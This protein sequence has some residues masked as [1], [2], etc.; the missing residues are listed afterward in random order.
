MLFLG[1]TFAMPR[2]AEAFCRTTT[3]PDECNAWRKAGGTGCCPYGLPL[4]WKNA[5]VGYSLQKDASRY[6]TLKKAT[7]QVAQAFE[8]WTSLECNGTVTGDGGVDRV[9]VDVRDLGPVTCDEVRYETNGPNQ[10][11]IVFRDD[12]WTH[13]DSDNTLGLTTV[14]F[15]PRTGEIRDADIEINTAQQLIAFTDE[16]PE[17][18]YDFQSI[19]THEAG[20]FLGLAHSPKPEAAM[21]ATHEKGSTRIRDLDEDDV[22]ALCDIYPPDGTRSVGDGGLFAIKAGSCDPTPP[23]GLARQCVEGSPSSCESTVAPRGTGG[24]DAP[25]E[26]VGVLVSI[27]AFR[28]H[29]RRK[30][31]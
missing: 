16:V 24:F 2:S 30:P 20:H 17:D 10:N 7:A 3:A 14:Q 28:W 8:R 18:K 26:W 4:Y 9:S 15:E 19:I 12:A 25:W 31:S 27:V 11:V 21:F 6:V 13:T 23:R 29:R 5:C 1:A 22:R